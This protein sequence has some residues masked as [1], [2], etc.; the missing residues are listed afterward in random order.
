MK[1][2][3]PLIL[4]LIPLLAGCVDDNYDLANVDTNVQVKVENLTLPVNIDRIVLSDIITLKEDSDV[5]IVDGQYAIVK[6]GEF[7]SAN[8]EIRD[9]MLAAPDIPPSETPILLTQLPTS[10]TKA[11]IPGLPASITYDIA[12]K[13]SDINFHAQMVSPFI[14][15]IEHLGCKLTLGLEISLPGFEGIISKATFTDVILQLPKG[16]DL[17]NTEGGTYDPTTGQLKMPDHVATGNSLKISLE[18]TGVDFNLVGGS[19]NYEAQTIG[20]SGSMHILQGYVTINTADI[21][22][23][24]P[25]NPT[26]RTVY[27]LSDT[28]VTTFTGEVCYNIDQAAL[29][30]VDLASLPDVLAQKETNISFTNPQIYLHIENPLQPYH[31]YAQTGLDITAYHQEQA[32]TYSLD[33]S[34]FTIGP[35]N[36]DGIY[37]FCLSPIAP[38]V[39]QPGYEAAEHV[40]FTSLSNVLSGDGIPS[41]L[42]IDLS[43]PNVPKQH[44]TN[45]K[46]GED[47]GSLGGKYMFL[48]P[49][50]FNPGS[51]IS[52]LHIIDGWSSEDLDDLTITQLKVDLLIST[53]VPVDVTFTG[54]PLGKDGHQ[55]GNVEILGAQVPAM[56]QNHPVTLYIT[57]PITG[58]DGIE[59]IA[60]ATAAQAGAALSPDLTVTLTDI[61]P[62][63]SGYYNRKL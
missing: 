40:P 47:L 18:A 15:S 32:D 20:V 46:L 48:A 52:Y 38:T 24:P 2:H 23:I 5:K 54:F 19:Y 42:K 6:D 57:G 36:A 16:L 17:V 45:L 12:N 61:R 7:T 37:N 49:L 60:H 41:S 1:I 27:T 11:A 51:K 56:A 22:G 31:L 55:I 9:I 62:T 3:H 43:D 21:I 53:D 50:Q 29:T 13:P 34:Y 44:V 39:D 8:V 28:D 14:V 10:S 35:D 30:T 59:F 25:A 4:S 33:N 63:V 58:L 26:L